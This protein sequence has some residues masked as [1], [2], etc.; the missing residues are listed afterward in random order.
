MRTVTRRVSVLLALILLTVARIGQAQA[1]AAAAPAAPA[2]PTG[3]WVGSAG[4]GLSLN[5]GN[6]STTNLNVSG[7]ASYDPK[8]RSVWRFKTLYL[9]GTTDGALAVDRFLLEVRDEL[10][11]TTRV[12][13]F[14][15]LQFLEDQFKQIDYLVAP[16][17]GLGYK[18]VMTPSTTFNVDG[19]FGVK[20][21][22][23][24]GLERRTDPVF[25]AGDKFEHKLSPTAT[26]TQGFTALW[27]ASDFGDALYNF[28]T[29]VAA[30]LTTRT[31]LKFEVIDTYASRPPNETV[32]KNDVAL[33]TALVYKF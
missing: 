2:A 29:G 30:G 27:K 31:Q 23:N 16:S 20:V 22:K 19:G 9:R 32:K 11:L 25:N 26:I 1:P 24:P 8:T 13:A 18:L 14:G 10:T 3:P 6:T 15:Q 7:E 17:G 12:Y 21:E 33:L 5:R 4:F 28:S